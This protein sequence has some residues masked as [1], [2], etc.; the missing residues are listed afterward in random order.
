MEKNLDNNYTINDKYEILEQKGKGS[1][2]IVY[3]V[4]DKKTKNN[5]A[6]KIFKNK[7]SDF[8]NEKEI[9]EK[10]SVLKNENVTNLIEYGEGLIKINSKEENKQYIVL[11]YASKGELF[12]Y[13]YSSS[14]GLNEKYAK[15]IFNKILK[16]VQNLHKAGICHRDLKMQNILLDEFFNPK[17]CD[18]GFA[19]EIQGKDGSGKLNQ[20]VGTENYAAPEIFLRLPYNGIKVDIFSLGVILFNLVTKKLGFIRATIKDP[21]YKYI[22]GKDFKTYWKKVK[23]EIGEISK[24]LKDLFIKMVSFNPKERPN[25]DEI[26]KHPWMKEIQDLNED[27]YKILEKEVFDEFKKLENN[28]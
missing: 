20:F 13:I 24:E 10:V 11:D 16:G 21:Y 14:K 8:E 28:L 18:F 12:D 26:F 4:E 17:I 25:I 19:T 22:F 23:N 7:T 6:M 5:Y 1:Y 2:G 9:L 15:F 27:E 3:L